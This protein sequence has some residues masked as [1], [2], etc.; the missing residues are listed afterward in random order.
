MHK[1][2]PLSRAVIAITTALPL[3]LAG[4]QDEKFSA[5]ASVDLVSV[6]LQAVDVSDIPLGLS[7]K[8]R[9]MAIYDD[10][11]TKDISSEAKWSMSD[12]AFVKNGFTADNA[13]RLK[14]N[15]IDAD[16]QTV[17]SAQ[18]QGVTSDEITL[19]ASDAVLSALQVTPLTASLPKGYHQPLSAV[20]VMSD[21]TTQDLTEEPGVVTWKAASACIEMDEHGVAEG[22]SAGCETEVTATAVLAGYTAESTIALGVTDAALTQI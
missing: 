15:A 14:A 8:V 21:L 18:Y 7:G 17:V 22:I 19:S 6:K 5:P 2:P 12:E 16:N 20:A 1:Q 13:L 4:C 10:G 3:L 11:T 9:A